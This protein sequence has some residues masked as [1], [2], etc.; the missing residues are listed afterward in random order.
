MLFSE[1]LK[2]HG[3][4]CDIARNGAEA[5]E[6]WRNDHY[7]V[8]L[9][10]LQMPVMDGFEAVARIRASEAQTGGHVPIIALTAHAME[11]Y[12]IDILKKGFD[13]YVTKPTTGKVLFNEMKRCVAK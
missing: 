8:I 3:H 4:G 13:G 7:D 11:S 12:R 2:T 6:K 9:M 1:M 5:L 10:D